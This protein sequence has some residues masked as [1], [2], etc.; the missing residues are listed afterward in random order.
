MGFY[1]LCK[2]VLFKPDADD[3]D[4]L[5]F[6]SAAHGFENLMTLKLAFDRI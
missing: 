3:K 4:L 2:F 1:S 5:A 6:F